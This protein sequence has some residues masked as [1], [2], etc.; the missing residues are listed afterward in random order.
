MILVT[1]ASGQLGDA[2]SRRLAARGVTFTAVRRPG[3]DFET[4]DTISACFETTK[5]S[6]VINAAAYTA[7][8]KAETDQEAAKAGNHTGPLALA[9]LCEA[10]D[11]P[12]IHI[13]TDYVFNGD[14]G[15]P[16]LESDPT[17]PTGVYGATKRDGEEA[18]LATG[19]KAVILR[20]AWVYSAH[21]KNFARTMINAGRKMPV[22]RVVADQR[23]TPTAAEDLA[24]AILAIADKISATGW[25][26][27]YRGVFHATGGGETTW[28]G[29][30]TAIFEEA[31]KHGYT[32]PDVQPIA[33]ADWPTPTR[34]PPDSRLDGGKLARVFGVALPFWHET[35]PGVVTDL[36]KLDQ[37]T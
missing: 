36:L 6:L 16:Y 27:E 26:P 25:Q 5:P 17:S 9:K 3:F 15:A 1:G 37:Q 22:L 23:G 31:A 12:F 28:H 4:P 11:I 18:I 13:S 20:T 30:A 29:F 21:G 35:L 10:A 7:V 32:A 14:K 33:T 19:A 24:D 2:L 34:R 8:D